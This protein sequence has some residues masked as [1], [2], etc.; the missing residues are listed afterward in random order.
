MKSQLRKQKKSIKAFKIALK[1]KVYEGIKMQKDFPTLLPTTFLSPLFQTKFK[2]FSLNFKTFSLKCLKYKANDVISLIQN[3]IHSFSFVN[4]S[5]RKQ[6]GKLDS[7]KTIWGI[8]S[9]FYRQ[10]TLQV[11]NKN[12]TSSHAISV[13]VVH[14]LPGRINSRITK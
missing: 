11:E 10:K 8:S 4:F 2:T 5:A 14:Q 9:N 3:T 1:W 6:T 7:R 13:Y 12:P